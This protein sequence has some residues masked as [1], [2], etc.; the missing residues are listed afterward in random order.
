MDSITI[1]FACR[2][3]AGRSQMA[4]AVAQQMVDTMNTDNNSDKRITI[5]SAGTEPANEI[6]PEVIQALAEIGLQPLSQPTY[7][8]R[9]TVERADWVITMGCGEKCPYVPGVH[10]ED[11]Q[12]A[13]PHNQPIEVVREILHD[14]QTRVRD[15]LSRV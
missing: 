11:W 2:K 3:N 14:I 5:L 7:L 12:V 8:G 9:E 4:A 15:L 6:H 1:V 10:Y 13:D